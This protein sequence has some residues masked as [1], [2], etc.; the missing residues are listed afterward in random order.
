MPLGR[1]PTPEDA[2]DLIMSISRSVV[3]LIKG[4]LGNQM[5]C[6]AAARAQALRSGRT[7]LVDS[8]TGFKRDGYN[9]HYLLDRFPIRASQ[10]GP[11]QRLGDDV[12][13]PEHQIVRSLSR[14]LPKFLRSYIQETDA[15]PVQQ[16]IGFR[17]SRQEIY[18]SGYWQNEDYFRDA[19]RAIRPELTPSLPDDDLNRSIAAE[20]QSCE[21]V[22]VHVRR[23]RYTPRL[24]ASYYQEAVRRAKEALPKAKFFVF[25]DDLQWAKDNLGLGDSPV[26][27][28]SHNDEDGIADMAL[29]CRCKNGII[30]NSSFSWW[31]A[32]L[33]P[34]SEKTIFAPAETGWPLAAAN[35]WTLV[36]N[37]LE[38]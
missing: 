38:A 17:S 5:F 4:G 6:Y 25:G 22:F 19:A 31:G 13:G 37:K 33:I 14:L 32:W 30:A 21:S 18:L 28:I 27:Y 16:M 36:P 8:R 29:M 2:G 7:L 23:V 34:G 3:A 26:R 15:K 9:R 12:K 35:G 20:A 10:A 1:S 24:D 11:G